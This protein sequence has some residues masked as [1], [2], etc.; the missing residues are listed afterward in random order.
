MTSTFQKCDVSSIVSK[1]N[2]ANEQ[3]ISI[4]PGESSQRQPVHTVYGGANL[5]KYN[6]AEKF[7]KLSQNATT[8]KK[9][10]DFILCIFFKSDII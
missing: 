1:L 6:T 10:K 5:F 7:G 3:F 8:I 4:Y 2:A 9:P